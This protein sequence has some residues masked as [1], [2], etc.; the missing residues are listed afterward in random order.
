MCG[1]TRVD[2]EAYPILQV[3]QEGRRF[4]GP[5]NAHS[6]G[7]SKNRELSRNSDKYCMNSTPQLNNSCS[8]KCV[9]TIYMFFQWEEKIVFNRY[10]IVVSLQSACAWRRAS[11]SRALENPYGFSL[12][13]QCRSILQT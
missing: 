6:V 3:G 1:T 4:E 7:H 11:N 8:L 2:E 5:T 9:F 12:V 10:L 13:Y